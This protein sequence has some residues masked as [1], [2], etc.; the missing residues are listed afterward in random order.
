MGPLQIQIKC[1]NPPDKDS[2][3]ELGHFGSKFYNLLN[4]YRP[5]PDH[6]DIA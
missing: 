5:P 1:R 3:S 4:D 6:M 2:V